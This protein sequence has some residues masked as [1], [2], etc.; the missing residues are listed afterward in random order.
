MFMTHVCEDLRIRPRH[1]LYAHHRGLRIALLAVGELL[2]LEQLCLIRD[3]II[4]AETGARREIAALRL[5]EGLVEIGA[6]DQFQIEEFLIYARVQEKQKQKQ[7]K[8]QTVLRGLQA[9]MQ[10][11]VVAGAIAGLR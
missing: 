8:T 9:K 6:H 4:E 2:L 3:Q 5:A 1:G 10:L 7:N 11:W